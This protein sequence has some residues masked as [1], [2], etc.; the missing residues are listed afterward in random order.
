MEILVKYENHDGDQS[1]EGFAIISNSL[2]EAFKSFVHE[3]PNA[4]QVLHVLGDGLVTTT[5]SELIRMLEFQPITQQ[6]SEAF[7]YL[8]FNN[9][10]SYGRFPE[11]IF[12]INIPF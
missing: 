6:Q 11:F 10:K 5:N 4:Q 3:S 1:F 2:Y 9:H 7:K 8:I 12:D